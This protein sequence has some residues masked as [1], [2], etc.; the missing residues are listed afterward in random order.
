MIN[1]INLLILEDNYPDAEFLKYN[2]QNMTSNSQVN[3]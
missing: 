3:E 2:L 1:R